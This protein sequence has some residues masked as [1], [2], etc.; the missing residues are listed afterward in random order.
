M[1]GLFVILMGGA[2]LAV[3]ASLALGIF[4][5]TKEGPEARQKSLKMMKMRVYL[6]GLAL[7]LAALAFMTTGK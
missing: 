7:L 4:Y 5:M 1:N 6:Q 3:V 2:M